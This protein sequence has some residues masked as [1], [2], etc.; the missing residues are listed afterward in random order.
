MVIDISVT[1]PDLAPK[2]FLG[3]LVNPAGV[4]V[5]SDGSNQED[6]DEFTSLQSALALTIAAIRSTI[7]KEREPTKL[8]QTL[9]GHFEGMLP[10]AVYAAVLEAIGGAGLDALITNWNQAGHES[11]D[12]GEGPAKSLNGHFGVQRGKLVGIVALSE[13]T[14]GVRLPVNSGEGLARLR[15]SPVLPVLAPASGL[16]ESH[17]DS[18]L[19]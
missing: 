18:Y 16:L 14:V 7:I 5:Q 13:D 12:F 11:M 17:I 10:A 8:A 9:G 2:G 19:A 3:N 1:R 4:Y 15:A 6:T